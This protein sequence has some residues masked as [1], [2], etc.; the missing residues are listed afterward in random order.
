VNKSESDPPDPQIKA[1]LGA[2]PPV[3]DKSID[4]QRKIAIHRARSSVGQ[5]DTIMFAFIKIWT[6]LADLLAPI[7]ATFAAKKNMGVKPTKINKNVKK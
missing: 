5:R 3:S 4:K 6:V 7:F 2:A 1:L